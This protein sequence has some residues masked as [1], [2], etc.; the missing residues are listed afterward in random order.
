M[1]HA[2]CFI[3]PPTELIMYTGQFSVISVPAFQKDRFER[4]V[5]WFD[6]YLKAKGF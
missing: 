4:Y 5:Q 6:K 3:V 2:L 1:Y